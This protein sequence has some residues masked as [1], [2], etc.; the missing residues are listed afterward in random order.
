MHEG[1]IVEQ[2][3]PVQLFQNPQHDYTRSL[4][5]AIPTGKPEAIIAAQQ[6]RDAIKAGV[7][8]AAN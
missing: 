5:S 8:V 3:I 7:V 1:R 6:K 4:I 2:G